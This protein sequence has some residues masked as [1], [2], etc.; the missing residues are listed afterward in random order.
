MGIFRQLWSGRQE[1]VRH[2]IV[3]DGYAVDTA[4]IPLPS[5]AFLGTR[6]ISFD[7]RSRNLSG[8]G[9]LAMWTAGR[10]AFPET[11]TTLAR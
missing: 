10:R 8:Q 4:P 7:I 2:R 6:R 11:T 3:P 5:P 9:M 1:V